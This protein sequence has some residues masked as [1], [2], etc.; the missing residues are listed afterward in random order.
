MSDRAGCGLAVA[1][2]LV[3][4]LCIADVVTRALS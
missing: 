1:V 2:L 3:V 4:W